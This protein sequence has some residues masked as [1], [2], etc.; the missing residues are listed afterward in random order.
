M[1]KTNN[2]YL[3]KSGNLFGSAKT[4]SVAKFSK[5]AKLLLFIVLV[6]QQPKTILKRVVNQINQRY[7]VLNV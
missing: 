3:K 7:N 4:K 2:C 1:L 5:P 6:S